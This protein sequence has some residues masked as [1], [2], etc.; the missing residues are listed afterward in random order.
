MICL[1]KQW[2]DRPGAPVRRILIG[3]WEHGLSPFAYSRPGN[4][5]KPVRLYGLVTVLRWASPSD[6]VLVA[7]CARGLDR[8][9]GTPPCAARTLGARGMSFFLVPQFLL[10]GHLRRA[11]PH[12]KISRL[13]C[14]LVRLFM[15]GWGRGRGLECPGS[16]GTAGIYSSLLANTRCSHL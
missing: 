16:M 5:F 10:W 2:F 13:E 14:R 1:D 9:S 7:L 4:P 12:L 8:R 15:L 3:S 11:R 6:G